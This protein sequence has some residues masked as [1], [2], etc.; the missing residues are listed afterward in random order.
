MASF[1][2][3]KIYKT[4]SRQ[5]KAISIDENLD[6][7]CTNRHLKKRLLLTALEH[8]QY[9]KEKNMERLKCVSKEINGS[10]N[11]RIRN[12]RAINRGVKLCFDFPECFYYIS[13]DIKIIQEKIELLNTRIKN[14]ERKRR[15]IEDKINCINEMIEIFKIV[16]NQRG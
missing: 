13:D 10:I 3:Q 5:K 7:I 8:N 15:K 12:R 9:L 6:K 1:L 14:L 11:K 2:N 16:I 4:N